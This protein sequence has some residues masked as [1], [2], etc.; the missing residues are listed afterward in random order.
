MEPLRTVGSYLFRGDAE[1]ARARLAAEG[2]EARIVADDEGGLNPGF[3]A[4]YRVRVEVNP[5]DRVAALG[6]LRPELA[7]MELPGQIRDAM[8]AHARFVASHEA[9][10][11]VA[12]DD[13]GRLRMAY[14]LTNVDRS[15]VRY[16]VS[17]YEHLRAL[18]H[19]ERLGWTIGGVFH[20]HPGASPEPSP[21]D[22]A[23]ALEPSW[24]YFIVGPL[25][26]PDVRAYRIVSGVP[27]EVLL[28]VR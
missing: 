16:T 22:I 20:S 25:P 12:V 1:V 13:D 18:L 15:A 28:E 24:L 27:A 14:C 3:F 21:V 26:D 5:E 8:I 10:G 23:G 4:D 19:A 7:A 11:L 17:P 9:C 6:V 2:I